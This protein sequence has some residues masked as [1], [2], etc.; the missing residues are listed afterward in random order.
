MN[1]CVVVGVLLCAAAL[2]GSCPA[3]AQELVLLIRH[4]EQGP[5]PDLVL[6]EAGHRRAAALAHRFKDTRVNAIFVTDATRT[7]E[8]AAPTAKALNVQP[9]QVPMGDI[10]LLVRRIRTEH[11]KDRVLI[12]N[13]ALNIPAI[14]KAFGDAGDLVVAPDDYERLVVI[15]PRG[16]G[17]PLVLMLR[18]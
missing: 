14:L 6:T 5:P 10:E 7:Q 4:A 12:V 8:T 11:A 13:H 3:S 9:K 2:T 15:V 1:R 17:P 18:L 16:E